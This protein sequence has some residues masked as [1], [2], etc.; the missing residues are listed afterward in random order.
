M[1]TIPRPGG[2]PFDEIR[3][4]QQRVAELERRSNTRLIT[5]DAG[6]ATLVAPDKLTGRGLA[7]PYIPTPMIPTDVPEWPGTQQATFTGKWVQSIYHQH[8]KIT[9]V[10]YAAADTAGTTGE[11][12][13]I[14][15]GAVF[16]D[17]AQ[18]TAVGSSIYQANAFLFGPG[19][20]PGNHMAPVTIEIQA[21]RTAG[22][23][24]VRL[25][26]AVWGVEA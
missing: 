1:P 19:L 10:V 26:P 23:G 3:K 17:S 24:W 2:D 14:I 13:V 18:V 11:I 9:L 15:G 8:P 22:T 4:L 20:W 16:S 6:G 12:R 25:W 7:R 5:K 21:R